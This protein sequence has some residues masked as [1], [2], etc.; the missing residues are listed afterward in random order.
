MSRRSSLVRRAIRRAKFALKPSAK[1]ENSAD[2]WEQRYRRGGNSGAGSYKR[3]A[4]F[5]AE[6]INEFVGAHDIESVIEFG[7]GDGAQLELAQYPKYIGVDVS[8]TALEST[9]RKFAGDASKIFLHTSEVNGHRADIALSLDVIYHL[10]EDDVFDSYMRQLFDA[11]TKYV[12]VYSSNE[13]RSAPSPH[14]RHRMFTRWIQEN[15]PEFCLIDTIPN[16]Y[17]H[18]DENPNGTSFCD[19]FVFARSDG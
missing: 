18:S 2:Y 4:R 3:L 11:A 1:F 12:I 10:V 17:P 13:D 8:L 9:R 6:V 15:A 19:F 7:S 16:R 5:K 14:V